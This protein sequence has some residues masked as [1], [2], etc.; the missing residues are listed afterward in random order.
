MWLSFLHL[1]RHSGHD[2]IEALGTT[3]FGIIV[4]CGFLVASFVATLIVVYRRNGREAMLAR[5][6]QKAKVALPVTFLCGLAIYGP[7]FLW[8]TV[9]TVFS[10][11]TEALNRI[12]VLD[13]QTKDL[14]IKGTYERS[15]VGSHT[16]LN[17]LMAFQYLS[18]TSGAQP[19]T[20]SKCH[21]KIT[22]AHENEPIAYDLAALARYMNCW[23]ERPMGQ[24]SLSPELQEADH[25]APHGYVAIHAAKGFPPAQAFA[26]GM[27]NTFQVKLT[28]D[29]PRGGPENLIWIEVGSGAIWKIDPTR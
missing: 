1:L 28:Y 13:S 17:T 21:I 22:S 5:W 18:G 2:F 19:Y 15:F 20:R 6:S 26:I 23:V 7:L 16:Y 3:W 8:Q 11:H 10:D 14:R 27:S 24:F 25:H 9:T 12:R 4:S 29:L